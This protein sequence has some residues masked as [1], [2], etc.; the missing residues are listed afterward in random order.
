METIRLME[1]FQSININC[2]DQRIIR[3]ISDD[4][5]IIQKDWIFLARKGETQNGEDYAETALSKGAVVLW[6][7]SDQ[8]DCYHCDQLVETQAKLLNIFYHH[9]CDHLCVIGVTGTNGKT[10]VSEIMAQMFTAIGKKTMVIGTG[11]IQY[12]DQKIEINNTTPSACVLAYYF[13]I[14]VAHE[15]PVLIMEVSS[16][17]IDQRRI[18][19]IRFDYVLYTNIS[20]DHLDYHITRTHYQYTKFKLR[21]YLKQEGLMIVNHDDQSLHPLY[22]FND[23]KIITVGQRQ[24]HLQISDVRL[25]IEGSTFRFEQENYQIHL[26]GMHNIYNITQCLVV[27]QRYH[28]SLEEKQAILSQLHGVAGRMELHYMADR[29]ILIDYA[30]TASSLQTLLQLVKQLDGHRMIVVCG[31]GG[32]RDQ[33]KRPKMAQVALDYGD[34]VI[35]TTDNPR[36]EKPCDIFHDMIKGVQGTYRIIE[37][38][39]CAIKYAVKIAQEHD[40]IIIAGKGDEHFQLVNG[41]KYPFSDWKCAREMIGGFLL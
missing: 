20:S 33:E 23:Y 19:F 41:H 29:Y 37:N 14:A 15:I 32:D 18:G 7:L 38:R 12:E 34:E 21:N 40:I 26:L 1:L 13:S 17:A 4:S 24:A 35:F 39:A 11:H 6:E 16:H 36:F 27:F 25:T 5:R 28:L 30:H 8:K 31:C 3:G 9:P 10:S 2:E 22:D